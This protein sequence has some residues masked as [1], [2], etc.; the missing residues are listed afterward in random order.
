[1]GQSSSTLQAMVQRPPRQTPLEQSEPLEQLA[2]SSPGPASTQIA[3]VCSG[4]QAS[5]SGQRPS[6]PQA[7][8]QRPDAQTQ[9]SQSSR[10]VQT[11]PVLPGPGPTQKP[12]AGPS[13]AHSRPS[14]QSALVPQAWVQRGA[15]PLGTQRRAGPQSASRA[16]AVLQTPW[17]QV[18]RTQTSSSSQAPPTTTWGGGSASVSASAPGPASTS[19]VASST[20]GIPWGVG[21]SQPATSASRARARRRP[22]GDATRAA[23]VYSPGAG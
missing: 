1:M 10:V 16:Q 23:G 2:S 20:A 14:G 18:P 4:R 7:S 17:T 11:V 5:P 9:V 13:T 22:P 8:R 3:W 21:S 15:P 6:G 12:V 19:V